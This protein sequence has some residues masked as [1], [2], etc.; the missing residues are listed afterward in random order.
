MTKHYVFLILFS[1]LFVATIVVT[2]QEEVEKPQ[3]KMRNGKI[4]AAS[5]WANTKITIE[6]Y[7]SELR[8]NPD[9]IELKLK[10]CQAYIQEGRV[11][12]DHEYYD[13]LAFQLANEVLESDKNNFE[14]LCSKATL[15]A[16]AHQFSDALI[17]SQQA[18]SINP[19]N[20]YIYGIICD[21]YVELGNYKK[22]IEAG[23]KMVSI[24][25]D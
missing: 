18:V 2:R 25:P 22:A 7:E 5:E 13:A 24:R 6:G 20:S 23:D 11:T 14:A 9:N 8:R 21:S 19:Y 3:L 17:T 1:F 12:G 4:S 10:L 16:S 15:Q